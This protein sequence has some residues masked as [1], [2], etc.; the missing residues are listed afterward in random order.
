[1]GWTSVRNIPKVSSIEMLALNSSLRV[2]GTW[3]SGDGEYHYEIEQM[4]QGKGAIY[5]VLCKTHRPTGKFAKMALVILVSRRGGEFAWKEMTEFDGP[6]QVGIPL[7]LY[8]KLSPLEDLAAPDRCEH[9]A[10]WRKAVEAF[11]AKREQQVKPGDCIEFEQPLSFKLES[12]RPDVKVTR[13]RVD[14]WGR[15]KRFTALADDGSTFRCRL[16]RACWQKEFKVIA[17]KP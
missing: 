10:G 16:R 11:H 6:Y 9:A 17:A 1:M 15:S 7:Y 4:A 8:R 3:D 12:G 14:T 2:G 13:F 5:G